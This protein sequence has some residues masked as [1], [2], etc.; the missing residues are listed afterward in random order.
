LT[1]VIFKEKYKSVKTKVYY[2]LIKGGYKVNVVQ[3]KIVLSAVCMATL[4][5]SAS[6]SAV[7]T[8]GAMATFD[9]NLDGWSRSG[10]FKSTGGF[11]ELGKLGTNRDSKLQAY[12]IAPTTGQYAMSFDYRFTGIDDFQLADDIA[13]AGIGQGKS[14]KYNVFEASSSS[15]LTGSLSNSGDWNTVTSQPITLYAGQKYWLGFE[16]NESLLSHHD[17]LITFLD[18][19]NV[20]LTKIPAIPAPGAI[21]LSSI[22]AGIVGWLRNRRAL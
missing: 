7:F 20:S 16:L 6:A 14:T 9:N 4:M 17:Q 21:L 8:T 18:V 2:D 13:S 15:G 11:A 5:F 19:D 22:G 10:D 3:M 12:F 1:H